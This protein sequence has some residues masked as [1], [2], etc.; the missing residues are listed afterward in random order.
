MTQDASNTSYEIESDSE[1]APLGYSACSSG[2]I[3]HFKMAHPLHD[4]HG[5]KHLSNSSMRVPNFAG[6]NRPRCDQ[7]DR[8]Y[9]CRTMLTLFKPW[10]QGTDLKCQDSGSW[11]EAFHSHSFS[12]EELRLMINFNI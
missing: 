10:R 3:M 11:D 8:E 2:S 12:K 1:G 4:S 5:V 6:A 9:Y 7:G